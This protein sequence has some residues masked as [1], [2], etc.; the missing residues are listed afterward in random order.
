META[1]DK[2]A[3]LEHLYAALYYQLILAEGGGGGGVARVARAAQ[4][5]LWPVIAH[6]GGD[7]QTFTEW[8]L[9]REYAGREQRTHG[10][11]LGDEA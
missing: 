6:F 3:M 8:R 7:R 11:A 4:E 1:E 5:E 2:A 9:S 10:A